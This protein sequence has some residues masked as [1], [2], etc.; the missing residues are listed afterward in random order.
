[1]PLTMAWSPTLVR[2]ISRSATCSVALRRRR[3]S[4]WRASTSR[5]RATRAVMARARSLAIRGVAPFLRC[6]AVTEPD[7][8]DAS[9]TSILAVQRERSRDLRPFEPAEALGWRG[10][11]R[12]MPTHLRVESRM[13]RHGA[14]GLLRVG[15]KRGDLFAEACDLCAEIACASYGLVQFSLQL[16]HALCACGDGAGPEEVRMGV[17]PLRHGDGDGVADLLVGVP[18]H[19]A[20]A[21]TGAAPVVAVHRDVVGVLPPP[22]AILGAA[23]PAGDGE[24]H[25]VHGD[26]VVGIGRPHVDELV[27][28][29]RELERPVLGRER[30]A[31]AVL[32]WAMRAR[33]RFVPSP[34]LEDRGRA[35]GST[36]TYVPRVPAGDLSHVKGE[37]VGPWQAVTWITQMSVRRLIT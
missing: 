2:S 33:H 7:G 3:R 4:R 36:P 14:W 34:A 11:G 8:S 31:R 10:A 5:S 28:E 25:A 22:G 12:P 9:G 24:L 20:D 1:M 35:A 17:G 13:R 32:I 30:G 27:V 37:Q 16:A 29:D 18:A 21:G 26:V 6:R 19:T 23:Q 15:L